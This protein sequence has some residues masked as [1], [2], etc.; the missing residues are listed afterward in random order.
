MSGG[1]FRVV[2]FGVNLWVGCWL[3]RA[4]LGVGGAA[5]DAVARV[6][7]AYRAKLPRPQPRAAAQAV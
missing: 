7:A 4:V 3:M 2:G 6:V 1:G 5:H